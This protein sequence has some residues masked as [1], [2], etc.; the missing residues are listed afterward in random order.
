M[1][2]VPMTEKEK[3]NL[4][5]YVTIGVIIIIMVILLWQVKSYHDIAVHFREL[6]VACDNHTIGDFNMEWFVD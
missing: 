2:E 5:F 6:Y 3:S 1:E 4:I